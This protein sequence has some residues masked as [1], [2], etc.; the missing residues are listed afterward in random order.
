MFRF[1]PRASN[2]ASPVDGEVSDDGISLTS[3]V[4][5][6]DPNKEYVVENIRAEWE[7]N[8]HNMFYLVEWT[9]FPLHESTW[10]P[11]AGLGPA[12]KA[13]WEEDKKSYATPEFQ[14]A[15]VKKH[16]DAQV[17]AKKQHNAR[18]RRR[19]RKRRKLGL[20]LTKP[21]DDESSDEAEE[22]NTTEIAGSEKYAA[23]QATAPAVGSQSIGPG[24]ARLS[25]P[26]GARGKEPTEPPQIG[27]VNRAQQT[28]ATQPTGYQGTGR[29]AS[30]TSIDSL[31]KSI[32]GPSTSNS[33]RVPESGP[34][35]APEN[36][37]AL[38]AKK[39]TIQP[40]GNI[41]T[42]G[43]QTKSRPN[44][45]IAMA[46]T[47]RE[48]KLF[49]KHRTRRLAE[50]RSRG[51][52]DMAPDISQLDLLDLRSKQTINRRS[53]R[54]S[55]ASPT[56]V[57]SPQQELPSPLGPPQPRP[58]AL[59][60]ARSTLVGEDGA[61]QAKRRKS[62]RFLDDV[63]QRDFV[64][65]PE[66]MD[67]DSPPV[68][69]RPSLEMEGWALRAQGSQNSDKKLVCGR[70][71]L[72][73][74]FCKLPQ[75]APGQREWLSTFLAKES[76]EF[77]HTCFSGAT[78]GQLQPLIQERLAS[79]IIIPKTDGN[80]FD[81]MA[82]NLAAGMLA[83]YHGDSEYSILLYPT[84][85]DEW[86]TILP[87]VV[88]AS[89]SEAALGYYIF[90]SL[91][92]PRLM[93]PPLGPA[94]APQPLLVQVKGGIQDSA[95]YPPRDSVF[96]QLFGF[97]YDKI[98]PVPTR[99]EPAEEHSF[100]LAIPDSRREISQAVFHWLRARNP[101][102]RV[103]TSSRNGGWNAFRSQ[104]ETTPGVV[105]IHELLAWNMRRIPGL[106]KFLLARNDE[107]W[108]IT[109][110]V[111]GLPLY[112]SI[113][114]PGRLEPPG[115]TRL[116]RLFPYRTAIFLAPSFFVSEPQRS[117]EFLRWFMDK[118]VGKFYYRLITAYNIHEYLAELA[119]ERAD[120][121]QELQATAGG[122][123]KLL[124][125]EANLRGLTMEDCSNRYRI[126]ELALDLHVTR[127]M[128]AGPFAHDEDNSTLV[129]AD[130]S[131]DPN[132]EQSL[133]N[134]FGWWATLRADQF[135]KFHVIGSNRTIS[136]HGCRRGERRVRIP[137]YTTVTLNDP[138]A[139][140]EVLQ[141]RND[142]VGAS[143][144]NGKA[145][146]FAVLGPPDGHGRADFNQDGQWVFRSE[147]IWKE[148]SQAFEGYLDRLS[149]LDG[150]RYQWNL[151]KF[152]ISWSD[153]EMA[154]HF[155]DFTR[156]YSRI[157]D[158]FKFT[159]PFGGRPRDPGGPK[160][161]PGYN[162]YAGFFYTINDRDWDSP[163]PGSPKTTPQRHP[164]IGIYRPVNP[165]RRPYSRC[166][167]IIWDP[168][169]RTRFP[170]GKGPAEK[171]LI[172]MQRQ[173]LQH[174]RYHSDEKN[175]GTWLDQAWYGGWD[176]PAE[177][178]AGNPID[179][180]LRFLET[181]LSDL[182][183]FLPAPDHVMGS[184]G[185]KKIELGP[186]FDPS[187]EPPS[188]PDPQQSSSKPSYR[189]SIPRSPD[190]ASNSDSL[191]VEQDQGVPMDI[192]S[193]TEMGD[194]ND[195]TSHGGHGASDINM[196]E[197][198]EGDDEDENTRIIFHPP[199]GHTRDRSTAVR[200][201]CTNRL[202]EAARLAR[203]HE[204]N[205][206]RTWVGEGI[207]AGGTGISTTHMDYSYLPTKE[208]YREQKAEGRGFAHVNVDSWEGVF[209][210]LKIPEEKRAGSSVTSVSGSVDGRR[211]E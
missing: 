123:S 201:R 142:Q 176:W 110:P 37:R 177:C 38:T 16:R 5:D 156:R 139:V 158:W 14:D 208:W 57:Q 120:A 138:D 150:S 10:E 159:F 200:S 125:T 78:Y 107:Y 197:A 8:N 157:L 143:E 75:S 205:L 171:D 65:E 122:D 48:P 83:L 25:P 50:L 9:D 29:R 161:P 175:P 55:A 67:I 2:E 136:Q 52:E 181:L 98:L 151:F 60:S 133:V 154:D 103:F 149:R 199:R 153:S 146:D 76:L 194:G 49:E 126:A 91:D 17:E 56:V 111:H 18:H 62:V 135:R 166:E 169:A 96:Q 92:E 84:K 69:Q 46:D 74:T 140:L 180:T 114:E 20:P 31:P 82:E 39:S 105:I 209:S 71:T 211:E 47:S 59:S 196:E 90:S 116:T 206:S 144:G 147:L 6:E 104:V 109:E 178:D 183:H 172:Y 141:E 79:G 195:P 184:K 87:N 63:D 192:D 77:G 193:V 7:D 145:G 11:E 15:W 21:I 36:R 86:K 168:T 1:N 35:P 102:C 12:L 73:A 155:G 121:R 88:P 23:T 186:P 190:V 160:S 24:S 68:R 41:F 101:K 127:I 210:A 115:D 26:L 134:W 51:K 100:F 4:K 44:L 137:K 187:P 99:K 3:T 45:A 163:E 85:S 54:G 117:L 27:A 40:A 33:K 119:E 30:K 188:V 164:W 204:H 198:A 112:P 170:N 162:T 113:P 94:P 81:T 118:W 152:P 70:L 124:K 108:C 167:V 43:K 179:A 131:I 89:P 64:E 13:N 66:Q 28:A 106:S 128:E 191:F 189:P 207:G 202:Y 95:E 203:A 182:H 174:V 130:P 93:L 19:N 72:E 132:D 185:W 42:G 97:E 129:Y 53:S 58:S 165:H 61:P 22:E 173:L 34:K 148:E 80:S 32:P